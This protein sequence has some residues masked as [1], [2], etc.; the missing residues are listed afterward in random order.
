MFFLRIFFRFTEDNIIHLLHDVFESGYALLMSRGAKPAIS[1]WPKPSNADLERS[2]DLTISNHLHS[3]NYSTLIL[4]RFCLHSTVKSCQIVIGTSLQLYRA[5]LVCADGPQPH[6]AGT[7]LK[8]S[9][10]E[11][12]IGDDRTRG[13]GGGSL[14]RS[15]SLPGF[16][17][18]S[19]T[20]LP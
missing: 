3:S 2:C 1:I 19:P 13:P 15:V 9:N 17:F 14:R 18:V 20:R 5:R 6:L 10:C 4:Q 16:F 7:V 11:S 12:T 8:L